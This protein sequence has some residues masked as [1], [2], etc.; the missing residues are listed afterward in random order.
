MVLVK[1]FIKISGLYIGLYREHPTRPTLFEKRLVEPAWLQLWFLAT[2]NKW[3]DDLWEQ[4]SDN[5]KNFFSHCYHITEQPTNKLLEIA[6][7][8]KFKKV[9]QRLILIEGIIMAGNINQDLVKEFGEIINELVASQQ[10]PRKQGSRMINRL[11]R[12]YAM[13][14][15]TINI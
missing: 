4:I 5:N 14:S 8:K 7:A 6:I 11:A 13:V 2:E 15:N 3:D 1:K 10:L 9:Q 12:T